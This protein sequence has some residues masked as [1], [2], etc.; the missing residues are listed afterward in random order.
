MRG[1]TTDGPV[2]AGEEIE[3]QACEY[4]F[5]LGLRRDAVASLADFHT[6]V[7]SCKK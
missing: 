4:D 1:L 5:E 2:V 7:H 6:D 3:Q